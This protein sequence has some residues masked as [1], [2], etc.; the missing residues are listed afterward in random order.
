MGID[1]TWQC[2]QLVTDLNKEL[3]WIY[4]HSYQIKKIQLLSETLWCKP[5]GSF[6]RGSS[7]SIVWY[8]SRLCCNTAHSRGMCLM[9]RVWPKWWQ[10][11]G[12][13]RDKIWDFVALVRPIRS[14]VITTSSALV[15]CR[16]LFGGPS[17]GFRRYRSLPCIDTSHWIW[18]SCWM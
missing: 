11:V 16:N 12:G 17:V 4:G 3:Y 13:P 9:V 1:S 2:R 10:V 18:T 8:S 14:R 7:E 6:Q 15:R 5:R